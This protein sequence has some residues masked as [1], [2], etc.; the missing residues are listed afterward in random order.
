[1]SLADVSPALHTCPNRKNVRA[2]IDVFGSNHMAFP[3]EWIDGKE[4]SG[5]RAVFGWNKD[6][7]IIKIEIKV[8]QL[9]DD[10]LMTGNIDGYFIYRLQIK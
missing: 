9:L 7:K 6:E 2:N 4:H 1:V 10:D 8:K 3:G 5:L